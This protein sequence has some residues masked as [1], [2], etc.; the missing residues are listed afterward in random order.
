MDIGIWNIRFTTPPSERNRYGRNE[1][2]TVVAPTLQRAL[3][4]LLAS[5]PDA[6]IHQADK[7]GRGKL[8]VDPNL[9]WTEVVV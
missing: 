3:E 2:H 5:Y 6:T 9:R 8:L 1:D 7:R 4:I